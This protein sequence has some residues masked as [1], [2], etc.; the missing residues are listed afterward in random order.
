MYIRKDCIPESYC[1]ILAS[2]VLQS[3]RGRLERLLLAFNH[4]SM[5]HLALCTRELTVSR[6]SRAAIHT[7]SVR[8]P[9]N[10]WRGCGPRV[11]PSLPRFRRPH[12]LFRPR[13]VDLRTYSDFE[14]PGCTS[15]CFRISFSSRSKAV[16]LEIV[17]PILPSPDPRAWDHA[18]LRSESNIV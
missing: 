8:L 10:G 18:S 13:N 16:E 11:N 4:S 12:G 3:Q 1:C 6:S 5:L 15:V 7:I 17:S 9:S 14:L 2:V